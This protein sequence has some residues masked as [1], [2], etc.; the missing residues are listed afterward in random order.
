M[1][2]TTLT[3]AEIF[4]IYFVLGLIIFGIVL[5][6]TD[7][8]WFEFTYA[9]EDGFIEW[10][11][12][13]PLLAAMIISLKRLFRLYRY[14]HWL[15]S[16]TL[17]GIAAFSFFAAGEELSWGQR[18][19]HLESSSFFQKNNSQH[20][21]N[22]HNLIVGGQS[23]NLLIFSRLLILGAALYLFGLP[24]IYQRSTAIFSF[25]N[26][27]GIPVARGYQIV[28]FLLVF[29]LI[30]LCPLGKRAELLEFGGC[31][32]FFLIVQFPKNR[33]IYALSH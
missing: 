15:F 28:T 20:E 18:L 14:R 31:Y 33:N 17:L 16:F 4:I 10:M 2:Q 29:I 24:I 11:T 23:I 8:Y 19:F 25:V 13:L 12:I 21:T 30:S 22:I 3:K 5:S 32:L 27:A 1:S 7:P 9:V 26:Q 6:R